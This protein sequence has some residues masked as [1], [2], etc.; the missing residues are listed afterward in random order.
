M[1]PAM[2]AT[3]LTARRASVAALRFGRRASMAVVALLILV[4]GVWGSWGSAQYV[5]LTKGRERGTIEVARCAREVC[6]GPYTPVSH[7]SEARER[8]V[9]E[10]SV[11]VR[12]GRTYSVVVKPGS[13]EVVRSGPAGVLYA[14]VPMGGALLL[15]SV[16]VAG[17]LLR[18]RLAWVLAG[19]GIALL[20]AAFVTI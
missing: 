5:M 20:T 2:P 12:E 4:A 16:V 9:I 7:G 10:K 14:W 17:G 3:A 18:T 19:S 1:I 13:A 6:S 11:A 15:A 8:V